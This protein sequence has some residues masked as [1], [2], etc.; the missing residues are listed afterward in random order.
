MMLSSAPSSRVRFLDGARPTWARMLA[1]IAEARERI[2]LEVYIFA[3]DNIGRRF[4]GELAAAAARGV[5][6]E[7]VRLERRPPQAPPG[8]R[9]RRHRR[10]HQHR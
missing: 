6:V 7:V 10:R 4:I 8:R 9:Q 1:A 3:N 2:H 5:L